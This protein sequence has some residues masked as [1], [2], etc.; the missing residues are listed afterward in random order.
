MGGGEGPDIVMI[1]QDDVLVTP[2]RWGSVLTL[3]FVEG[4]G[5]QYLRVL[6]GLVIF[7][8]DEVDQEVTRLVQEGVQLPD[9]FTLV[10]GDLSGGGGGPDDFLIEFPAPDPDI[11]GRVPTV[12]GKLKELF[13]IMDRVVLYIKIV[14][15][16]HDDDDDEG[17]GRPLPIRFLDILFYPV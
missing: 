12:R 5:G 11:V 10:G 14:L 9:Q 16:C 17:V 13:D 8:P 3:F 1:I 15:F 2:R 4:G 7:I 6:T